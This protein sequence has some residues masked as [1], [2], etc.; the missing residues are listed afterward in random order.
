MGDV[1]RI[2]C[3]QMYSSHTIA[4]QSVL[5]PTKQIVASVVIAV[6]LGIVPYRNS[7]T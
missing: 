4:T 7:L 3:A 6:G 1:N 5:S 2:V